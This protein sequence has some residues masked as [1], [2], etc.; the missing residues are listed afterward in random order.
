MEPRE[1]LLDHRP[2][3]TPVVVARNLGRDGERVRVTTLG[4][5]DPGAVDMLT[6]ILIGS[7]ETR[8]IARAD[9]GAWVYTPRGYSEAA[10]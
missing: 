10:S 5:L 7:S 4:D 8:I 6:V 2:E 1:I 3:A 9:G